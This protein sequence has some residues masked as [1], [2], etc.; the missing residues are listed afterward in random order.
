[1][2]VDDI[3][4]TIVLCIS[5]FFWYYNRKEKLEWK[6]KYETLLE[7]MKKKDEKKRSDD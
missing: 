1:M 6:M 3:I 5:V 2:S 7:A 4:C